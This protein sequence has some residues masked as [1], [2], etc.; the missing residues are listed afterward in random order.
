MLTTLLAPPILAAIGLG[1][2]WAILGISFLIF[3]HEFGHYSACR[4]TG[5]RVET[6]SVGFGPRLF[7]WERPKGGR[8]RFT[9]GKRQL[10][11]LDHAMDFRIALIPLGGYVKMAGENP[12]E[13]RSGAKDEFS[14][15]TI[16]QR[17]FIVSAGVIN[18]AITAFVFYALC[19]GG[20][21]GKDAPVLGLVQHGSPA[22]AAGLEPGDHVVSIAGNRPES[23]M[24]VRVEAAFLSCDEARP[25]EVVRDGRPLTLEARACYHPEQGI[26]KLGVGGAARLTVGR[27]AEAFEIGFDERVT[28]G[29]LPAVGGQQAYGRILEA[30]ASGKAE[31]E[32]RVG[33]RTHTIKPDKPDPA[34]APPKTWRLGIA[35]A[36]PVKVEAAR[37]AAAALAQGD[38]LL[39][40]IAGERRVPLADVRDF[41]ALDE[42]LEALEAFEVRRGTA[43]VEIKVSAASG[44]AAVV[45]ALH[46]IALA[47][48]E[49]IVAPV[50]VG[51]LSVSGAG[52]HLLRQT[53]SPAEGV[54]APGTRTLAVGS[55]K[56]TTFDEL[57]VLLAERDSP[58]PLTLKIAGPDGSASEVRLTPAALE[59]AGSVALVLTAH[60]QALQ[61]GGFLGSLGHGASRLWRETVN[62]FRTIGGF[63]TGNIAFTK[64]VAGPITLVS[65]SSDASDQGFLDLLWFLAYVSVMLAVLN[66]LPIPVL[67]GGH[68][69]F[70]AAEKL[71]GG[72][73][74]SDA[75]IGRLQLV[76]MLLLLTLMFFALKNDIL[77]NF[78]K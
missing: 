25:I 5:T 36:G 64:N 6:F 58:D 50:A 74:L 69:V 4:L 20:G 77:L 15:K 62:T 46:D 63:F 68:V 48:P 72:R 34:Q 14:S 60:K 2:V 12:G 51:G 57:V 49:A 53:V 13:E 71:R 8:R 35:P 11:P 44:R 23:F 9:V 67:D 21:L 65:V 38:V 59:P 39:A 18:N 41:H 16:P 45:A 26:V 30:L 76:G 29:G 42:T 43:L 37:G 54:I 70:L 47:A 78:I 61:G 22:W 66:V 40:A 33:D 1:L 10:D 19:Y 73:P 3:I 7:G 17:L 55:K 24:D 56:V 52:P 31:V 32:V 75:V 28:V 27:G